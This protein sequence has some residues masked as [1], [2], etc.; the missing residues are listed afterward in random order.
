MSIKGIDVSRHNGEI[1]WSQ[2]KKDEINFA[3]IRSSYGIN[4]LDNKFEENLEGA[5]SAGINTGAYHYSYATSVDEALREAN[6]M[7]E[8]IQGRRV[9]YPVV[10]DT[11]ENARL[12]GSNPLLTDICIA[13]CDTIEKAGYYAM[14]YANKYWF[15]NVLDV[16]RLRNYTFWVAQWSSHNT[17]KE[18]Y[19]MWQ[20]SATGT[21]SGINSDTDLDISYL[22]FESIIRESGLNH[23]DDDPGVPEIPDHKDEFEVGE[24]VYLN[25]KLYADSFGGSPSHTTYSNSVF[26]ISRVVDLSRTAPYLLE[27]GIGW[28][29]AQDLSIYYYKAGDKIRLTSA[30]IYI[31]ASATSAAARKSGTF[32]I[33]D[34]RAFDGPGEDSCVRYRI[35]SSAN[36]VGAG[37]D[38]VIGY[39][40]A[41]DISLA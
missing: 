6:H 9:T 20:H 18:P 13:F 31:S 8:V 10:F 37:T 34:G 11:E 36:Q 14:I 12:G 26:T 24:T 33:Y 21:V 22:D 29:R 2:V 15:E 25:G 38:K 17:F 32:Y 16:D 4:G 7:L 3:M 27:H 19:G 35:V 5:L 30:P 28:A 40:S 23:L 39:V 41:C 1:S